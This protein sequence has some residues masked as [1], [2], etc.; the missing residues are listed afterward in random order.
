MK[1]VQLRTEYLENPLGLDITEPR[2][3][4]NCEGGV[5]QSA[6]RILAMCGTV[7]VWDSGKVASDKMS[8]IRYTGEKLKSRDRIDWKVK[9]WDENGSAGEWQSSWFEMGLL[10]KYD[11]S[12]KWI[13]GDYTL[14][15][16]T[17]YPVDYFKKEFTCKKAVRQARLYITACG[18]YEARINGTRV[19]GFQFAPGLTDYRKRLHYQTYDVTAMLL[20]NNSFEIELAD[21]WYRGSAGCWGETLVY[22]RQTKLLCQLEIT[23][24]DNRID[25]IESD[26]SFRWSNDGPLRFADMKDG[27]IHDANVT[28][29]YSGKA[30]ETKPPL[31]ELRASN[32]VSVTEHETFTPKLLTTPNGKAVLDFGQNIAGYIEFRVNAKHGQKIHITCGEKLDDNGEFTMDGIQVLKVNREFSLLDRVFMASGGQ[33]L[34]GDVVKT[35]LQ[36]IHLTCADGENTYKTKF[37]VFGFRYALVE[38]DIEINPCDFKAI[39]VYS[40]METT[41][42]FCCS[43]DK[44]NRLF[45]NTFWSMKSNF[46]DVPTDCPQRE[47]VPWTG[48][49]QIFFNTGAFLMNVAPFYRKWIGDLRDGQYKNGS[50]SASVPLV[51]MEMVYKATGNSAGWPDAIVLVPYRFWKQYGDTEI[52]RKNYPMIQKFACYLI[53]RTGHK[54][55]KKALSN[56]YNKYVYEKGLHLGEWLEPKEFQ[57]SISSKTMPLQTEA[58]TAYLHYTM[59]KAAEIARELGEQADE[60]LFAEYAEGAK[61]AY[62]WLFLKDGAPDTDRQAKLVRPLALGLA[63]GEQKKRLQERLRK[64]VE[65]RKYRIGT[66]FLSTPFV[67]PALAEAGY[68]DMAYKMLENEDTPG[69]LAE[70][71]AGATTIW[72]TWEG[73]ASRNHYSPGAVCEWLFN[74][75]VGINVDGENHFI[76]KPVPGGMFTFANAAYRSIYGKIASSWEHGENGGHTFSITIPP[77]TGAEI[78]LPNGETYIVGCGTYTYKLEEP[79]HE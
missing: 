3:Y 22:G 21:G 11:W 23:G 34:K 73:E 32:N 71:N 7:F 40:D 15:K 60:K 14:K 47:R 31:A 72:E 77:N 26:E 19:G 45:Q 2:F 29:S 69:W 39:A 25:T 75:V 43:N 79:K 36:E 6:Y 65:N 67:L 33:K 8:H 49:G 24:N 35:P 66:G 52:L 74:T 41:G 58:A 44:V 57:D 20:D 51:G 54:N 68:T 18:L 28:P 55:R 70:V 46:L 76:I 1:A 37:A 59:S 56:P 9:L 64:A 53:S 27:E 48:D 12:A 62:Q 13:S 42:S 10:E 16:N 63:D 50:I 5:K 17:R 61:K 4:W 30:L 38:T 78:I